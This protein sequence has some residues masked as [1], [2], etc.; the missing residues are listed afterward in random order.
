MRL[1]N[2]RCTWASSS[3]VSC[4]GV[5]YCYV[6]AINNKPNNT[7]L[8]DV[9]AS[10]LSWSHRCQHWCCPTWRVSSC[11]RVPWFRFCF[12]CYLWHSKCSDT[13]RETPRAR[14]GPSVGQPSWSAWQSTIPCKLPSPVCVYFS[15][16]CV[17]ISY[18][19]YTYI[20]IFVRM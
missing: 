4:A 2:M 7:G 16:I 20:C 15:F 17:N 3:V 6:G 12:W 13:V 5:R 19:I 18:F 10:L 9:R 11:S 14:L 1:V 8:A